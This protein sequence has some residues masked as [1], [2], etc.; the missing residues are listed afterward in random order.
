MHDSSVF[1]AGPQQAR[2]QVVEVEHEWRVD[3]G[4]AD[5]TGSQLR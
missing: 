3:D 1:F 4:V 2:Q 5:G